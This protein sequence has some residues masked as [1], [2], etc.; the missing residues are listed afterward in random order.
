MLQTMA[1]PHLFI[2]CSD[3]YLGLTW[4]LLVLGDV[5]VCLWVCACMVV[6]VVV[7]A[8]AVVYFQ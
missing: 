7:V 6:V 8:A 2:Y 4:L 5:V 1:C 3:P